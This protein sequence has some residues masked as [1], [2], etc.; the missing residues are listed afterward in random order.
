MRKFLVALFISPFFLGA[1]GNSQADTISEKISK[2]TLSGVYIN[3]KRTEAQKILKK[4]GF[5]K[6]ESGRALNGCLREMFREEKTQIEG[7]GL[8]I[9]SYSSDGFV[10]VIDYTEILPVSNNSFLDFIEG[11]LGPSKCLNPTDT[12]L[13]DNFHWGDELDCT[14]KWYTIENSNK[15]NYPRL[16]VSKIKNTKYPSLM[17][18]KINISNLRT[19]GKL[20]EGVSR[21]FKSYKCERMYR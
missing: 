2:I 7:R 21:F 14:D 3:M 10:A 4:K 20:Y 16:I 5:K 11:D 17:I 9:L 6:F 18:N 8:T 13:G 1:A 15:Q 12:G 19:D